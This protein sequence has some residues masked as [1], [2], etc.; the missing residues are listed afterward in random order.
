MALEKQLKMVQLLLEHSKGGDID[1]KPTPSKDTMSVTFEKASLLLKQTPS[2]E[3]PDEYDYTIRIIND[4][5][6]VIESFSDTDFE[7]G[8]AY[9]SMHEM[10]NLARRKALGVD[11]ALDSIIRE[12]KDIIPF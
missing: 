1:W 7:P 9:L 11:S 2:R 10:F 12:L 8:Q 5:G 6:V 4:D 3:V